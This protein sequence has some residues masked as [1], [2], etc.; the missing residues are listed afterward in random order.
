M[1]E[2]RLYLNT[3]G[4]TRLCFS[5]TTHISHMYLYLYHQ[6]FK[7][8]FVSIRIPKCVIRLPA[9]VPAPILNMWYLND[10]VDF[11]NLF[12]YSCKA[13]IWDSRAYQNNPAISISVFI[14]TYR[15]CCC[16]VS[17]I[18]TFFCWVYWFSWQKKCYFLTLQLLY[19][20][21]SFY[22]LIFTNIIHEGILFIR[23]I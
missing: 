20:F 22:L 4:I 19:Q 10:R 9:D 15:I 21:L 3:T 23:M 1:L 14:S 5:L 17:G 12:R 13:D 11:V 7:Y 2:K 16:E 18:R 8:R 6:H